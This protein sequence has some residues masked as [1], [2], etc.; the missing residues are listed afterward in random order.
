MQRILMTVG[1]T[2]PR[3]NNEQRGA[4]ENKTECTVLRFFFPFDV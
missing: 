1:R 3:T 4:T 2:H